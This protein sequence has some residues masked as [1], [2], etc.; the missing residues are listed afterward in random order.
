MA[1]F[2]LKVLILSALL[3]F[4]IKY[5]GPLLPVTGTTST[6]LIAICSP[7]ILMA[8]LFGW[9]WR[10]QQREELRSED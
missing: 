2:I 4:A 8:I 6:V 7:S 3:S 10:Q 5:G 1:G 9:R